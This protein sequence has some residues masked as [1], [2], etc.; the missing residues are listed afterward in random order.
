MSWTKP[1]FWESVEWNLVSGIS[2]SNSWPRWLKRLWKDYPQAIYLYT[3]IRRLLP[4]HTI[5]YP[6]GPWPFCLPCQFSCSGQ[7]DSE[8]KES[9][10]AH[11]FVDRRKNDYVTCTSAWWGLVLRLSMH[12]HVKKFHS[13]KSLCADDE[14]TTGAKSILFHIPEKEICYKYWL[15]IFS[16]LFCSSVLLFQFT[17][18]LPLLFSLLNTKHYTIPQNEL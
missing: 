6:N 8:G 2:C 16:V 11:T 12:S 7:H 15:E 17:L 13:P 3:G 1:L 5:A 4:V 10:L 9:W 18:A 14:A